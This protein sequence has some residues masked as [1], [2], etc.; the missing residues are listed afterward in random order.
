MAATGI[1]PWMHDFAQ[2]DKVC[3]QFPA[4][5]VELLKMAVTRENVNTKIAPQEHT[6]LHTFST[7]E[8]LEA[9][10]YLRTLGA[11]LE[12]RDTNQW[13]PLHRACGFVKVEV[14]EF[15]I[16]EGSNVDVVDRNGDTCLH[17]LSTADP[18]LS[19]NSLVRIAQ[20]LVE[21]KASLVICNRE[22]RTPLAHAKAE[23]APEALVKF[24]EQVTLRDESSREAKGGAAEE[25]ASAPGSSLVL[26]LI[27]GSGAPVDIS[28]SPFTL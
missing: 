1:A 10:K 24:L 17:L 3:Q 13:T 11:D 21:R 18:A 25:G 22:G 26:N 9:V 27:V 28:Q 4:Q 7:N 19:A 15:L 6:L 8:D 20:G 14:A 5:S 16:R 23:N 12:C 2:L